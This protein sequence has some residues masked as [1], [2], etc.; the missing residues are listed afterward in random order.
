[1]AKPFIK[2]V[3]GKTQLLSQLDLI[4]PD[5]LLQADGFTYMEP[6]VG[7]GAML[8]HMLQ[9]YPNMGMA[10]INDINPDL[11]NAYRT[12]REHPEM[13]IAELRR[14][15]TDFRN[16]PGE[17]ARKEFFLEVRR[18]YNDGAGDE[19][20]RT[21]MFMFLNRTC[22][23]GLYRVNSRGQFNVPFG[24]Y[25]NPTICDEELLMEDS[26]LL[27]NVRI[28]CGDYALMERYVD[29]NTF[30]Y[31][32]PPYRPISTT[33]SFTSYSKD[34]FDD[35]DQIRLARFFRLMSQRG[36]R[37]MLSNSCSGRPDDNFFEEL[38][39]GFTIARVDARRFINS[40]PAKRGQMNEIVIR[41]YA[42]GN[43]NQ[44][45][46]LQLAI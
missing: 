24:K 41:N 44:R 40:N 14:F 6:F 42:V 37:M 1:M 43:L 29:D 32:D 10:V 25:V 36:C 26:A 11:I 13:L 20:L 33:S 7:G 30:I 38:Y 28:Y 8:F 27:Q 3:G 46:E 21:A 16:L 35:N 23:N 19:I 5:N 2:W 31:F 4:L 45:N 9:R 15:Q 17:E 18:V 22:F 34:G 39:G 12:L